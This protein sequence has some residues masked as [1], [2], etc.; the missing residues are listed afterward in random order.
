VTVEQTPTRALV[1]GAAHGI[2]RAIALALAEAGADVAVHYGHSADEARRPP[3]RSR[4][5]PARKTFAGDV[6]TPRRSTRSWP[7]RWSSWAGWTCWFTKPGNLVGRSPVAE[8]TDEHWHSVIDVK[9]Q[10]QPSTPAGP[11]Y[12]AWKPPADGS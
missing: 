4:A 6:R 1:T 7:T 12:P 2:G 5:G 10:L 3:R 9:P 11:R 8:M